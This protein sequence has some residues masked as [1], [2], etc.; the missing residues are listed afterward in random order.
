MTITKPAETVLDIGIDDE[1]PICAETPPF[2]AV[3]LY[4]QHAYG[5]RHHFFLV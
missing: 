1:C 4:T 3:T 2:N 5:A